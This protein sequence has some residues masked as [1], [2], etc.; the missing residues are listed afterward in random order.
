MYNIYFDPEFEIILEDLGKEN[1]KLHDNVIKKITN[2]AET[3][4]WSPNHY[5][6]LRSPLQ[7]YKRVHVNDS[8]VLI[9]MVN[10]SKKS[11]K[12]VDYDHH[13]NIYKKKSLF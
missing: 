3:L 11:V 12:F 13:D 10:K 7:R 4:S 5:K 9:F 2:I 8:Y 6:N 1:P